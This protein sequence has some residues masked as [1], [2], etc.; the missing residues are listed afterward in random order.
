MATSPNFN[1]PE[2]DNTDL[3]KNGALAIR[4][5]VN[6]IDSSLVDLK[7]GTTGQVLAKASGTDMDF[8]WVTDA[9]GIP[10][11]IFDAK[12]DIIAA[13]AA[14]TASRLAVGTNGQVLTA[15][16]A[17]ATG[18]KWATAGGGGFPAWTSYTPTVTAA[19]GTFTYTSTG[20]YSQSGTTVAVIGN[21]LI[22]TVGTAAGTMSVT[23]PFTSK[24][25]S[26]AVWLGTAQEVD[27]TGKNGTAGVQSNANFCRIRDYSFA[28][29]FVASYRVCFSLV[30]EVA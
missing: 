7:G 22:Q 18:L 10:A 2:P 30:Y 29:F 28:T 16:S 14:D 12:G 21:I 1:W 15:D 13:T 19:G 9:T 5:A 6:A 26:D 17:E 3:V 27:V 4:T 8:S 24:T 20:W 11:T 25:R 23:L